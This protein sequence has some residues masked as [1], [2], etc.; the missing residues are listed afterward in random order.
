MKDLLLAIDNGTQSVRALVFDLQGNLLAKARVSRWT[1][2]IAP[3][4]GLGRTG[5]RRLLARRCGAACQQLWRD[6]GHL[7]E[8]IAGVA[9]TTQRSTVVNVD[10]Q[11]R[12]LRPAISWLD[13]RRTYGL[14]PVG[15]WWGL[16]FKL[17]GMSGHGRLPAGRGRGQLDSHPPAR[18][19]GTHPQVP[20]PLRLPHLQAYR[21]A[22]RLG[23]LPGRLCPVRLQE[24]RLGRTA[25]T[26]N[27]R[28]CPMPKEMLVDLVP[29]R[30]RH[31][32]DY[33]RGEPRRPAFPP[34]CR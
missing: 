7:K 23:G 13:Q 8:R 18:H 34:G 20:L 19:L 3:Q 15:G 29:P 24:A 1:P 26:G 21:P 27:G 14:K 4:P 17:V 30:E 2:C 31:R 9:L 11:G 22:G 10:R 5:P 25:A 16:A 12:P 6:A 32:R 33:A 28:R